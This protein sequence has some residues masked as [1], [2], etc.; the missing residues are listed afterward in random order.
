MDDIANW[1]Q[2]LT[3]V[4]RI[5][6]WII[7]ILSILGIIKI[8]VLLVKSWISDAAKVRKYILCAYRY[9]KLF[10]SNGNNSAEGEYILRKAERVS[11]LI[12]SYFDFPVLD[13]ANHIKYANINSATTL[14][15]CVRRMYA[16]YFAW[17]EKRKS[18]RWSYLIELVVPFIWW[19]F[20]GTEVIVSFIGQRLLEL[21]FKINLE[22]KTVQVISWLFTFITGL[23]S[24]LSYLKVDLF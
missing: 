3:A 23:A 16:N 5:L 17:D 1:Y 6:T 15:D 14:D 24:L 21:G 12:D 2:S 4:P 22:S 13:F 9:A 7:I 8:L 19:L 20:R 10:R 11:G 18:K